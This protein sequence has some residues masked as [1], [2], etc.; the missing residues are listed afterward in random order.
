M[1]LMYVRALTKLRTLAGGV[2]AVLDATRRA[3]VVAKP[4]TDG[5]APL[6]FLTR[7]V[8]LCYYRDDRVVVSLGLEA[9]PPFPKG[10]L[11]DRETGRCSTRSGPASLLASGVVTAAEGMGATSSLCA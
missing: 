5:G 3:E 11:L 10:H 9:R 8:L 7:V 1:P 6:G 2:F 4:R